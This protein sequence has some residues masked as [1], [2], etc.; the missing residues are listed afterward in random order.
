MGRYGDNAYFYSIHCNKC[1]TT[2]YDENAAMNHLCTPAEMKRR[3]ERVVANNMAAIIICDRCGQIA[4]A[5][6]AGGC[7][8]EANAESGTDR[9]ALCPNCARE[10]YDFLH[11]KNKDVRAIMAPFKPEEERPS[12]TGIPTQAETSRA[13][14]TAEYGEDVPPGYVPGT[15]VRNQTRY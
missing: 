8:Y 4:T 7:A 1:G 5:K 14:I 3:S 10:L 15:D 6:V 11:M 12:E 9:F 2:C 13:A